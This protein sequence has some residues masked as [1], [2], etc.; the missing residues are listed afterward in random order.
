MAVV[1]P[2]L[3]SIAPS[4]LVVDSEW[5]Y[6]TDCC[7]TIRERY[8][9]PA[10]SS[11]RLWFNALHGVGS[12]GPSA[13]RKSR[14]ASPASGWARSL[15]PR[16]GR[17]RRDAAAGGRPCVPSNALRPRGP[18]VASLAAQHSGFGGVRTMGARLG[19][20]GPT[21]VSHRSCQ[22]GRGNVSQVFLP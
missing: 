21:P 10:H 12:H 7:T 17:W 19:P 13:E 4:K 16:Q 3:R 15:Q 9:N 22:L 8:T 20:S 14:E 6:L 18:P 11:V 5:H 1:L 2:L